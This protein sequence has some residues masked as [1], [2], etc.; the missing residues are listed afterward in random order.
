M[1]GALTRVGGKEQAV[2]KK[3]RIS[4]HSLYEMMVAHK[5]QGMGG[6]RSD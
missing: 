5:L 3:R 6:M 1:M 2:E 4:G